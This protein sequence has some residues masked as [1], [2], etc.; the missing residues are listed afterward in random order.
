MR[1][2]MIPSRRRLLLVTGLVIGAA[3]MHGTLVFAGDKE[4]A[5]ES[6]SDWNDDDR[7]EHD[8]VALTFATVGDS[9]QDPVTADATTLPL[10]A[11]DAYWLQNSKAWSRIMSSIQKQ[12]AKLLVFN[13]DNE[14]AWRANMGDLILDTNRFNALFGETP[15]NAVLNDTRVAGDNITTD[16]SKLTYSFDFHGSHFAIIN[17]DPTHN[18]AHAPTLW[19]AQDLATAKANGNTHFFVFGHKPGYP[20]HFGPGAS[21]PA[22]SSS[23]MSND[24]TARN[25]FWGVI[26]QYGATYFCGHEHIYNFAQP[27]ATTGGTAWQ[28]LVG[29]G[30]SPFEATSAA[31]ISVP[32]DR[33]YAWA[34]VDVKKSGK[35][36]ITGYGFDDHFGHTHKLQ[37][38]QLSH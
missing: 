31:Q 22:A 38:I 19:L 27:T 12:H 3:A 24:V 23:D 36:Q 6:D 21:L 26:E 11:Q 29:S 34:K 37:Q 32:T 4:K 5:S 10:S 7:D 2:S 14:N 25:A 35:V 16:Q 9:R 8:S 30:G 15:S 13:G 18:D 33:Y 20:Y 28:I 1:E 17:T